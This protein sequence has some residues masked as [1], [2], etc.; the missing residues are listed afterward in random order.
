MK[1]SDKISQKFHSNFSKP[2][3]LCFDV[4]DLQLGLSVQRRLDRILEDLMA[5]RGDIASFDS[6]SYLMSPDSVAKKNV[7]VLSEVYTSWPGLEKAFKAELQ[8]SS[9]SASAS[10]TMEQSFNS[11]GA[12]LKDTQTTPLEKIQSGF[13]ELE[14]SWYVAKIKGKYRFLTQIRYS[15]NITNPEDLKKADR[16]ILEAVKKLPVQVNISGTRQAMEAILSNLVSELLRLGLYAFF[17]VVLIFF[18][19][20]PRPGGVA[21]CLIPMLGALCITLGVL[22][23]PVWGSHSPW[24]VSLL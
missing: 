15:E 14:R 5:E 19:I 23:P 6:I 20:L 4:E 17:G 21:L 18:L 10:E 3:N 8:D 13:G 22:G 2:T 11:I 24:S 9:L 7:G 12:I 1:I 16:R